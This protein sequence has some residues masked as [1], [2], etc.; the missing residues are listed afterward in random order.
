MTVRNH[1]TVVLAAAAVFNLMSVVVANSASTRVTESYF[2][3]SAIQGSWSKKLNDEFYNFDINLE[4]PDAT[5]MLRIGYEAMHPFTDCPTIKTRLEYFCVL[6]TYYAFVYPR[7]R[8]RKSLSWS[9]E[10]RFG[11]GEYRILEEG[12]VVELEG[13]RFEG[14]MRIETSENATPDGHKFETLYSPK[15]GIVGIRRVTEASDAETSWLSDRDIGL[16]AIR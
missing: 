15:Y 3:S 16:G 1:K 6:S 7:D 12:I 9:F 13:R 4:R 5:H 11:A 8:E 14:V 10:S 2:Y